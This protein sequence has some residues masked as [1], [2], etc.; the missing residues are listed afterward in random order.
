MD[1]TKVIA[2]GFLIPENDVHHGVWCAET[3]RLDHDDF[4]IPYCAALIKPGDVVIDG[5]ALFG[6]HTIA[7]NRAA[8]PTG[9]IIAVEPCPTSYAMLVHNVALFDHPGCVQTVNIALCAMRGGGS[10][11]EAPGTLGMSTVM[12]GGELQMETLDHLARQLHRRPVALIKLDIEGWEFAA[13]LGARDL[14]YSDAPSLVIEINP[15]ALARNGATPEAIY[16]LLT[17]LG[18]TWSKIQPEPCP[19]QWDIL[20]LPKGQLNQ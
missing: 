5:G 16:A 1:G 14:L 8:G 18:Y 3:Q 15:G 9:L 10:S 19:D 7:Y 13:L 6:D 2:G 11:L 12:P 17:T 4:L 20:A